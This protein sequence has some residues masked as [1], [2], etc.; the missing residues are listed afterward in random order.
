MERGI[1]LA[2]FLP[3]TLITVV[4]QAMGSIVSDYI[5]LRCFAVIQMAGIATLTMASL[6]LAQRA[7]LLA[8]GSGT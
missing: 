1:A 4:V 6:F 8:T 5:R 7:T 2:V 3:A